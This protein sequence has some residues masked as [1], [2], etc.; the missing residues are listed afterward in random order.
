MPLTPYSSWAERDAR[1]TE[2][3]A[4]PRVGDRF[5]EMYSCWFYV[6]AVEPQ[7]RVAVMS[8]IG[9]CTLPRDG[10]LRIFSN[11]DEYREYFGYKGIAGY[12]V[13]LAERDNKVGGWFTG[14]PVPQGPADCRICA[15]L[16]Q[17]A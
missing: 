11:H 5:H 7:G 3:F 2:A 8:G 17:G 14:W 6:I 12:W 16:V 1:T 10:D 15:A 13:M 9:P 4:E